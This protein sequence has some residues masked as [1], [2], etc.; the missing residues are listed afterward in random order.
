MKSS[1]LLCCCVALTVPVTVC[2]QESL[3][4][5]WNASYTSTGIQSTLQSVRVIIT[6]AENGVVKGTATR[7]DKGCFGE[8]PIEGRV[9]GDDIRVR[10]TKKGGPAGDCGFGFVGRLEGD[11]IIAKYGNY[12]L[13]FTK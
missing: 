3:V 12:E 11:K 1:A 6:S 7:S 8:Y 13:T 5:T 4:G 2:A 10:A 9:K